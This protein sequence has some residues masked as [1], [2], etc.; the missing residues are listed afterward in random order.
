MATIAI[1]ASHHPKNPAGMPLTHPIT[2]AA[3]KLTTRTAPR[4]LQNFFLSTSCSIVLSRRQIGN[5]LFQRAFSSWSC[6]I[7]RTWSASSPTY[8]FFQR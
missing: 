6:F 7:C 3:S 2:V 5:Q 4:G 1:G 8:C